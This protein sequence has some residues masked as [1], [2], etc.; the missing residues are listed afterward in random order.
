M[1]PSADDENESLFSAVRNNKQKKYCRLQKKKMCMFAFVCN[2]GK[3]RIIEIE[4]LFCLPVCG[5]SFFLRVY[6]FV[7]HQMV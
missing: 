4:K 6:V 5:R 2:R 3:N 7:S 1:L